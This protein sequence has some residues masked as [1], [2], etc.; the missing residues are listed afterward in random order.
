MNVNL[1][2]CAFALLLL[3]AVVISSCLIVYTNEPAPVLEEPVQDIQR[4]ELHTDRTETLVTPPAGNNKEELFLP[5]QGD[6]SSQP[7]APSVDEPVRNPLGSVEEPAVL[8]ITVTDE[9]GYGISGAEVLADGAVGR[10]NLS[11]VYELATHAETLVLQVKADGF[12]SFYEEITL[13]DYDGKLSIT[14][15]KADAIRK[16]LNGAELHPYV[17]ANPVLTETVDAVLAEI[18]V[19]GM[20][21]YDK[22]KACY[23]WLIDHTVYKTPSHEGSGHWDCA[24]QVFR[25]GKGTCNCYSAA[26]AAMMRRVGLECYV[27]EGVTSA[28]RG[29]M[30]GHVWTVIILDGQTYIFDPQVEDAITDRTSSKEVEYVRFCLTE[31]NSKYVYNG[32]SKSRQMDAFDEFLA[33][34]GMFLVQ[35]FVATPMLP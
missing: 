34:N 7:S 16:L 21:T 19:P 17:F 30:T 24:Y 5:S 13:A 22:V 9:D 4:D 23:D 15:E 35:D 29:G 3:V 32:K 2:T 18:F 10:T 28:N 26:F 33:Q 20:D 27:V 1:R 31:P 12:V 8:Q 14:L 6:V 11:G 25:D